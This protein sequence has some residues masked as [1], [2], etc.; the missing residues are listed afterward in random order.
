MYAVFHGTW[1][2]EPAR[3]FLWAET[4][5]FAAG[6]GRHKIKP[7]PFLLP[8]QELLPAMQSILIDE[9]LNPATA[10]PHTQIVWLPSAARAP[11][12]SP[13]LLAGGA[14][15]MPTEPPELQPWQIHGLCL[16]AGAALDLLLALPTSHRSLAVDVQ[17]WHLAALLAMELLAGQQ[18]VPTLQPDTPH[19]KAVWRPLPDIT[20]AQQIAALAR[21]MPPLC[22]AAAADPAAAAP[23][24]ELLYDFLAAAIDT[25][26]RDLAL[27]PQLPA[28]TP[29]GMWLRALLGRDPLLSLKGPPAESLY[30][31]WQRWARQGQ[32]AGDAVFRIA[33]RLEAPAVQSEPWLLS[34][35]LQAVDDP[36]LLVSADE[37]WREQGAMFTYLDRRFAH[38]QDRLLAGLGFA[39]RLF[40]PLDASLHQAAPAGAEL[41]T[42]DAFAFLKEA[43]PLLEQSGFAVLV[44]NWWQGGRPRIQARAR[45]K[46]PPN[47]KGRLSFQQMVSFS[48]E[49]ALAGQDIDLAEFERLVA[50]KTP[51][52]QLRGQWVVLDP[53][54]MQQALH[55]FQH[56]QAELSALEALQ[57]G[58]GG[59]GHHL[60]PG[61]EVAELTTEGWLDEALRGL[62]QPQ[63]LDLL[64]QPAALQA[65]LRPYQQRGFSWLAFL[66]RYGL[67]ACLADDM[68]LGKTIQTIALLLY[69]REMQ[70]PQA[71]APAL[72]VCPTSVVGNWLREVQRFAPSL[73]TMVHQGAGRQ[74]AEAFAQSAAQH[75]LV[76]TSYPLLS[77]D[78]ET[79]F[80]VQWGTVILDEAQN[81]KNAHTRQARAARQLPAVHRITLTG[82]PVENRLTEL[83]SMFD[84]LNPGYLGSET[85]FRRSFARPIERTAD[86]A[87]TAKLKQLTAP[88]ILRRLK[89]DKS[90]ISDL[91]DKIETKEYCRL[92][93]EQ[94]T[95]YEAV[96]QDALQQLRETDGAEPSIKRQGQVLAMLMKLKQVCNHPAQFLKDGSTLED[97]SGKLQRLLELLES[98]YAA[99]ERTLIFTQFS[100]LGEMLRTYLR[101]RFYEE[102]LF[103][104]GGTKAR[105]RDALVRRFQASG[106]P[107]MFILSIKAGGTGLNL[108]AASHVIHFDRW[109]NPAVENQATDRAFRIG[110]Q[111]NVQVH[112][113]ICSGTLEEH[114]DTIIEQK[115]TLA[116]NVLGADE[117]WL[118]RLSTSELR[119]L[120]SLRPGAVEE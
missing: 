96:V 41:S 39:A 56:Q 44:P 38:P 17:A 48:W 95:L 11:V 51:L 86:P 102:V 93:P 13:E 14:L 82:T 53:E 54:Q 63:Q 50:L 106:G 23:A 29:G 52:V 47:E 89:T 60:P 109:W 26:I 120:V 66:Q 97:R 45:V 83:W 85:A 73:R 115:R 43:A 110:Q 25:A 4:E 8:S 88:F 72:L 37:I 28:G 118:T 55:F 71:A 57:L 10:E 90:I 33:F 36:S 21:A 98:I 103:L 7:H 58:L 19:L 77:R 116:E 31:D 62:Q 69:Q 114:I 105:E 84:F 34:Y 79:F 99:D 61:V 104:H 2:P 18:F 70:L 30:R 42:P 112:K 68:G 113:F 101:E 12:P 59:E 40:P 94:A 16:P 119:E 35:L 15:T 5:I 108:T 75:D 76:L 49:L 3:F 100:E 65:T 24:A 46:S 20:G 74:Q 92:T 27:P 80:A 117:S 64:P 67:G 1:L 111:R 107:T 9:R 78:Q 6:R 91:P 81:I 32:V 22:R 87:A